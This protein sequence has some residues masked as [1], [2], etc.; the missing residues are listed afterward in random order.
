ML[1]WIVDHRLWGN[2]SNSG[3]VVGLGDVALVCV[4]Q[5]CANLE[6]GLEGTSQP[7]VRNG[8][9]DVPSCNCT[10]GWRV[11]F[12]VVAVTLKVSPSHKS[13]SKGPKQAEYA[14]D[15]SAGVDAL[16]LASESNHIYVAKIQ[17][18]L[19][20]AT[21]DDSN[22]TSDDSYNTDIETKDQETGDRTIQECIHVVLVGG[23]VIPG[24]WGGVEAHQQMGEFVTRISLTLLHISIL[25][26]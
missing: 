22:D 24:D 11:A 23:S 18:A 14:I 26:L 16:N 17:S 2:V 20:F 13:L 4:T 19:S 12:V 7:N 15:P 6:G 3:V 5:I 8:G 21:L 25:F 9:N 10:L 1:A